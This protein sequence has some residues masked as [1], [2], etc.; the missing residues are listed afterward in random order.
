MDEVAA[1]RG[2]G[3]VKRLR[4]HGEV[5]NM[6]RGQRTGRSCQ[7]RA[8]AK[9]NQE[10]TSLTRVRARTTSQ[11]LV[12]ASQEAPTSARTRRSSPNQHICNEV[13]DIPC[14]ST[15]YRFVTT[16]TSHPSCAPPVVSTRSPV[17]PGLALTQPDPHLDPLAP[18]PRLRMHSAASATLM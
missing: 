2:R 7:Y 14:H 4:V 18:C 10:L 9:R 1:R 13:E 6:W 12:S 16:V 15:C 5:E 17:H 11:S 3:C 8:H